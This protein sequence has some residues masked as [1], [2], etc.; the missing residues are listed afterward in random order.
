MRLELDVYK[1]QVQADAVVAQH[2]LVFQ[3]KLVV[4]AIRRAGAHAHRARR[5]GA[6]EAGKAAVDPPEAEEVDPDA[7]Q[8]PAVALP[9]DVP[10]YTPSSRS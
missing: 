5:V 2:A 4:G 10:L 6:Q 3:C 9:D 1:R 8:L 7:P